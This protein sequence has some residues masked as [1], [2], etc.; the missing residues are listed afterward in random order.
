MAAD[1]EGLFGGAC[2][3]EGHAGWRSL[4]GG[5]EA[6]GIGSGIFRDALAIEGLL[7]NRLASIDLRDDGVDFLAVLG[8]AAIGGVVAV[9]TSGGVEGVELGKVD[10]RDAAGHTVDEQPSSALPLPVR[11]RGGF[12]GKAVVDAKGAPDYEQTVGDVVGGAKSEF[13]DVGVDEEW[14][15]F[16]SERLVVNCVGAGR[17]P[18]CR[19]FTESNDVRCWSRRWPRP[20]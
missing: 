7:Q 10:G 19:P 11:R 20:E 3:F 9:P 6:G 14:S 16:Q 13:L 8:D 5:R 12:L 4:P 17:R 18:D 15:N 1:G 2:W